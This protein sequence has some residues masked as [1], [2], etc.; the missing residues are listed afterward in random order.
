MPL[1]RSGA[2]WSGAHDVGSPD[3]ANDQTH[4]HDDGCCGRRVPADAISYVRTD[5][6]PKPAPWSHE[7]RCKPT[8][9][10]TSGTTTGER[11]LNPTTSTRHSDIEMARASSPPPAA[12]ATSMAAPPAI[13]ARPINHRDSVMTLS[14]AS[15]RRSAASGDTASSTGCGERPECR[16]ADA[17]TNGENPPSPADDELVGHEA[18]IDQG[19]SLVA[20]QPDPEQ[21][22]ATRAEHA[23]DER[24]AEQ[25]A[26]NL[27]VAGPNESHQSKI[28]ATLSHGERE[29]RANDEDGDEG[30]DTD[31]H[32]H[33]DQRGGVAV[34]DKE[35]FGRGKS[36]RYVSGRSGDQGQQ[37]CLDEC[38]P[39]AHRDGRSDE[40]QS[41]VPQRR[42]RQHGHDSSL[43][44]GEAVSDLTRR[45]ACES[46]EDA[47]VGNKNHVIGLGRGHGVVGHHHDRLASLVDHRPQH[48]QDATGRGRVQGTGRLVRQQHRGI[49]DHR[50]GDRHPLLLSPR[51]LAWPVTG[52]IGEPDLAQDRF[53]S[54]RDG[55]RPATRNGIDTFWAAVS[56]P[57]KLKFWFQ[58]RTPLRRHQA[59][60]RACSSNRTCV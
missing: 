47:P 59:P 58:K 57:T 40:E 37:R 43:E 7:A 49:R 48:C 33:Q 1:M 8:T 53:T 20:S 42:E 31:D 38:H 15:V 29:R 23:E 35:F 14:A 24:L 41:S 60:R 55:F 22:T 3:Q 18:K 9:V 54:R 32:S 6:R 39:D 13:A 46:I 12:A 27:A 56:E 44:S 36:R 30:R 45:G 34:A 5:D 2:R 10:A 17:D 51:Q 25:K 26:P 52:P 21:R 50:T 28:S 11:A 16:D 19:L 4:Q